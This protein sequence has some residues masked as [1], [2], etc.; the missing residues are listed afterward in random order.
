MARNIDWSKPL[1]D[2]DRAWAMQHDTLHARIK[3]NDEEFAGDSGGEETRDERIETL[4]DE[5]GERQTELAM[6]LAD[7][8]AEESQVPNVANAGY[9]SIGQGVTDNTSVGDEAPAGAPA[10]V[11][12]YS[13]EKYWTKA[14]LADEIDKRNDERAEASLA[15]IS[16]SGNR[17][18]LVERLQQDD[19]EIAEGQE[20]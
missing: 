3:A 10:A 8:E 7:K 14:K 4:R 1:S 15:P 19:R 9:P 20:S 16:K 5:I 11:Q 18:E 12:D 6:L 13:D 2:E 17:S